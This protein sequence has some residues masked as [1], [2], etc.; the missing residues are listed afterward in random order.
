MFYQKLTDPSP[1][2]NNDNILNLTNS[3]RDGEESTNPETPDSNKENVSDV[4][5]FLVYAQNFNRM[6]SALKMNDIQHRVSGCA[7]SIILG[8]E[9]NWNEN[10]RSEEV[11]NNNFNVFRSDRDLLATDKK[12]GGGVL[13]AISVQHD[14]ELISTPKHAEFDDVWVKVLLN[15]ESHLFVSVYFPPH[16][17]KKSSYENFLNTA[18]QVINNLEPDTKVHIYGDFNQNSA[19]FMVHE[20]NESLLLPIVGDNEALQLIFDKTSQ[21]GLHQINPIRNELNSFL[22]FLFTNCTEDFCVDKAI[23]PLWKNEKFHTAIEYSLF[24]DNKRSRPT[25]FEF[26]HIYDFKK[27]NYDEIS[28]R[29]TEIEWQSLLKEER[30]INYAVDIFMSSLYCVIDETIPKTRKKLQQTRIQF[31]SHDR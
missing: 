4:K 15:D 12:S 20:D 22:D 17:A 30:D 9:T 19:D 5:E 31:G 14:A 8:T 25:E 28:C 16:C 6:R 23:S 10:I 13:V 27:A 1:D 29:L 18:E 24:I 21:L 2:N 11:F 26:E 7:Y 3:P